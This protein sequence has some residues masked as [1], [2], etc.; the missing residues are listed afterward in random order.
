MTEL[1]NVTMKLKGTLRTTM[2]MYL[3][4]NLDFIIALIT[5]NDR[6]RVGY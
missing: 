5:L 4:E 3:R 1:L 6:A 2:M